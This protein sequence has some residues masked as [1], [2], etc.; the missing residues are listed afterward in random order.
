MWGRGPSTWLVCVA[1]GGMV[2]C[3]IFGSVRKEVHDAEALSLDALDSAID[4]L[5]DLSADWQAILAETRDKLVGEA[6]STLRNEVNNLL[7]RTIG[8]AGAEFRCNADF[9]RTRVR[10][11]LMR[12]KARLLHQDVPAPE[13]ALCSVTPPAVDLSLDPARRSLL[14]F[15]GYDLDRTDVHVFHVLTTGARQEVT[16][17]LQ[18]PTHYHM[19]LNLGGN[20][21]PLGPQSQAI[22]LRWNNTEISSITVIQP[23]TPPCRENTQTVGSQTFKVPVQHTRGDRDFKG[24]GPKMSWTTSLLV[25]ASLVR[26]RVT[27]LATEVD[28]QGRP[29]SDYTTGQATNTYTLFS[30]PAGK[31][32]VSVDKGGAFS[33]GYT[34]TNHEIDGPFAMSPAGAVNSVLAVGDSSGDDVTGNVDNGSTHIEVRTHGLRVTLRESGNCVDASTMTRMRTLKL[35]SPDTEHRFEGVVPPQP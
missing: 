15:F 28:D 24:H 10:Q 2:G 3:G 6:Q 16:E 21:V 31:R 22:E 8:A 34:D 29:K 12:I 25:N 17:V 4:R 7:N 18:R 23:A 5:G 33:A 26:L 27:L 11:E 9:L 13:P 1:L 32:V 30:A 20:G 35:L 14:E 19:T